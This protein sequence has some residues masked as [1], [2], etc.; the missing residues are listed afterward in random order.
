MGQAG[1]RKRLE[2]GRPGEKEATAST[3]ANF[4]AHIYSFAAMALKQNS[5]EDK[6]WVRRHNE[7]HHI[8][9]KHRMSIANKYAFRYWTQLF[10]LPRINTG[11][12]KWTKAEKQKQPGSMFRITDQVP[13]SYNL[14]T[15]WVLRAKCSLPIFTWTSLVIDMIQR[16]TKE[17]YS[18]TLK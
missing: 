7:L 6:R 11:E 13:F 2:S 8:F 5:K 14:L 18:I 12:T 4:H 15:F 16:R 9:C 10:I 17:H 1:N 3:Q